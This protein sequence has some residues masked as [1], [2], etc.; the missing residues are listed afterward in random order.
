MTTEIKNAV[1][2]STALT[3]ADHGVLT[4]WLYLDYGGSGQGFGGYVLGTNPDKIKAED[5]RTTNIYANVWIWRILEIAGVDAWEK[6][7]GQSIRVRS[8]HRKI[9]AIGHLLN[10]DWFNPTEISIEGKEY[11]K[12]AKQE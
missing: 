5:G 3:T 6:L 9:K 7:P 10:D 2:E 11:E 4:A 1:I 8:T 12:Q